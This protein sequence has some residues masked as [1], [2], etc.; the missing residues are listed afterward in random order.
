MTAVHNPYF[1]GGD[2]YF[3]S[4]QRVE[5]SDAHVGDL[6]MVFSWGGLHLAPPVTQVLRVAGS[7]QVFHEASGEET[8]EKSI[9]SRG[10]PRQGI[11]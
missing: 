8:Q 9:F 11:L 4:D 5:R 1:S 3:D 6:D 2:S 7:Q 10:P